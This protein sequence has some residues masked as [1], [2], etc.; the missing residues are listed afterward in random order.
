MTHP[1]S[2][3]TSDHPFP[4]NAMALVHRAKVTHYFSPSPQHLGSFF[5]SLTSLYAEQRH[6]DLLLVAG[7][8]EE[9]SATKA[10]E[11]DDDARAETPTAA[12][13][14]ADGPGRPKKNRYVV[15]GTHQV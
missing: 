5:R 13:E 9:P 7:N 11:I 10:A 1:A 6:T 12:T 8:E 2:P 14:L 3:V 15:F 4:G